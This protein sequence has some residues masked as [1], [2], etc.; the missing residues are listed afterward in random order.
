VAEARP[1]PAAAIGR[2]ARP[3]TRRDPALQSAS[4]L[5]VRKGYPRLSETFIAQEILALERRGLEIGIVSLRHPTD[6]TV[7]ALNKAIRAPVLYLPEYLTR[8]PLRVLAAWRTVRRRPRYREARA[9][10]LA[11]LKREPSAHR[12]R[13]FGQALVLAAE[14]RAGVGRLHAHFLHTPASVTR[15]A[16]LLT[17]LPW[18]GSAHARDIW[19]TPDWDLGEKLAAADWVAVC[20]AG[21]RD[22]L[23]RLA[24]RPENLLLIHHGLDLERFGPPVSVGTARDGRNPDDPAIVLS[25]GRAV[26]KKGYRDLLS[27]LALLPAGLNWRF[28]HVGGGALAK[29]L[30]REA[31]RL[32]LAGRTEWLGAQ[33]Q[34][35]VLQQYRRAD[36]FVL[37][38]RVA[39]DGDRDGL[40]NVLMEAQSQGLPVVATELP[41]VGE[42]VSDGRNGLLVPPGDAAAIAR[43]IATLI[44]D[45]ARR[46]ALGEAG[47]ARVRRDFDMTAGIDLLA[48]QFGIAPASPLAATGTSPCPSPSMHP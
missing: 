8:E 38:S 10:W 34:D 28:V 3:L 1:A 12:V 43:A 2:A 21:G 4:V 42:L 9:A 47:L 48:R 16:A 17:G 19:T 31:R 11:D 35:V 14:M 36:L 5:F 30:I 25:V 44:A 29:R 18:S 6:R 46:R 22:R 45:P 27:A 41:G 24:P 23:A 20:N 15:Y 7:H 13:R 40:P 39:A 33:S 37:A 26:P 32:G